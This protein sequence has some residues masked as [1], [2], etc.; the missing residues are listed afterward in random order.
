M[1]SMRASAYVCVVQCRLI[2]IAAGKATSI[3][4]CI[5]VETSFIKLN[6]VHS[7]SDN[8]QKYTGH[9]ISTVVSCFLFF[10]YRHQSYNCTLPQALI[11]EYTTLAHTTNRFILHTTTI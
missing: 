5:L 11:F 8:Q 4:A 3:L 7:A 2:F 10:F 1:A 9:S 6:I